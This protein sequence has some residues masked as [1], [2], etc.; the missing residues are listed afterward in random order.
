MTTTKRVVSVFWALLLTFSATG[1][2]KTDAP[3]EQSGVKPPTAAGRPV[4][5]LISKTAPAD[6]CGEHGVPESICTRCKAS[7]IDGFKNKNDWC[8][9]H[10]L[11]ESQCVAC[12]PDLVAKFAAMAPKTS[13]GK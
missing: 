9:K 1:C 13:D 11:P 7:L 10:G 2:G 5:P 3:P 8:K 12:H 4:T 6:W